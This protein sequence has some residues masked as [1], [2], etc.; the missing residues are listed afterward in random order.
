MAVGFPC[1]YASWDRVWELAVW[2]TVTLAA[3]VALGVVLLWARRYAQRGM[4]GGTG[5]A[6]AIPVERL[7][8][9]REEGLISPEEFSALRRAALGLGPA[10]A[11]KAEAG[12]TPAPPPVDE[13]RSGEAKEGPP[14][15]ASPRA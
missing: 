10:G 9:M 12:L 15:T 7:K 6:G 5:A 4:R 2:L 14:P 3:V 8:Q 13:N 11:K 1:A